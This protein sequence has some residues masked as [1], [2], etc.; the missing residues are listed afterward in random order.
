MSTFFTV[1]KN[2]NLRMEIEV[3]NNDAY[4]FYSKI[5]NLLLTTNKSRYDIVVN[6]ACE[7]D[8]EMTDDIDDY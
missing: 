6:I 8:F 5:N 4:D 2:D 3:P 7:F 1:K